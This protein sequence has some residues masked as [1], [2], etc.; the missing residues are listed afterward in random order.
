M[1]GLFAV[2]T[3]TGRESQV[4]D[5][6]V[7]RVKNTG[8]PVYA[9]LKPKDIKGYFFIEAEN[10]DELNKVIYG[11][12]YVKGIIGAVKAEEIEHFLIPATQEQITIKEGDMVEI[13]SDPFKGERAKVKRIN[14]V[15]E[16]VVVELLETAVPIPITV[17]LDSIRVIKDQEEVK[18]E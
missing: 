8:A 3:T 1:A 14:K 9:I 12:Q 13:V 15:K 11:I 17:K 16:E 10:Q 18:K 2:R 7:A 5:K 4:I 6:I